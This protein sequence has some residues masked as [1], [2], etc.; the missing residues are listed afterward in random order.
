MTCTASVL[1][2][3]AGSLPGSLGGS[4]Y[5]ATPTSAAQPESQ[6]MTTSVSKPFA[7]PAVPH[8]VIPAEGEASGPRPQLEG[9]G[10]PGSTVQV[11]LNGQVLGSVE[12]SAAGSFALPLSADLAPGPYQ[13]SATAERLG[14]HSAPSEPRAFSVT[15]TEPISGSPE[16]AGSPL[17]LKVGCGCGASEAAGGLWLFAWGGLLLGATR[18]RFRGG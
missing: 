6:G 18:R 14:V 1:P 4:S 16:Q 8:W 15:L 7:L 2:G 10:Q 13:L 3:V 9:T 12:V 5:G 11:V 17:A